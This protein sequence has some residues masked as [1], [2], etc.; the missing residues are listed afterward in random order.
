MLLHRIGFSDS[1]HNSPRGCTVQEDILQ[2]VTYFCDRQSFYSSTFPEKFRKY[3]ERIKIKEKW[4]SCLIKKL[5]I[6]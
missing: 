1:R 3:R 6:L 4:I 5:K 2:D